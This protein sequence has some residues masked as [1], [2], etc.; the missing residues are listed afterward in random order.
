MEDFIPFQI[1]M[2]YENWEFDLEIAGGLEHYDRYKYLNVPNIF[3]YFQ[4]DILE[5]IEIYKEKN[6]FDFSNY[7]NLTPYTEVIEYHNRII[8]VTKKTKIL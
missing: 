2:H 6:E 4:L 7:Y 5:K 1:G 8:L 3:V